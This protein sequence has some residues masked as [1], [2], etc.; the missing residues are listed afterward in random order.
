MFVFCIWFALLVGIFKTTRGLARGVLIM[1]YLLG[2][3]VVAL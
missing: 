2:S 1:L 3:L